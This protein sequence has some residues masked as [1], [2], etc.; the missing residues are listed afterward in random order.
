MEVFEAIFER[1]S[2]RKYKAAVVPDEVIERL[3]NAARFAPSGGNIQPWRFIVITDEDSRKMLETISPGLYGEPSVVIVVCVDFG[4][5]PQ[6]DEVVRVLGV[7]AAIQNILIA[8]H[9]LGLG[10]CWV[11]S[12]NWEGVKELSGIP[13]RG[14]LKPISLIAIGYPE[15]KPKP[16]TRLPMEEITFRGRFGNSWNSSK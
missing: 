6:E 2:V 8:A 11:Y 13:K 9:A 14:S 12:T 3:V 4:T 15:E 5:G 1:R 16:R 7:G 10:A